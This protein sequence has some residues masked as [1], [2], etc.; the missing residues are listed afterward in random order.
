MRTAT[1]TADS[2]WLAKPSWWASLAAVLGAGLLVS[3]WI[4]AG[5]LVW[6]LAQRYRPF[7]FVLAFLVLVAGS[8]FVA[9]EAGGLTYQLS[10]VTAGV[11]VMLVCYASTVPGHLLGVRH[12]GMTTPLLLFSGLSFINIA[13]GLVVGHSPKYVLLEAFPLLALATTVLVS[14]AFRSARDLRLATIGLVLIAYAIGG[15]GYLTFLQGERHAVGEYTVAMPGIMGIFLVNLALRSRT[16]RASLGFV[17]VSLPLFVHQF[18]TFGR[19]LWTACAAGLAVS[20]LTHSRPG[21]GFGVRAR[22]AAAVLGLIVGMGTFGVVAAATFLDDTSI[23][24]AA[25]TRLLSITSTK[26]DYET[27]SNIIRLWEYATAYKLVLAS[28]W[29]GHGI[30]FQ[31]AVEDPLSRKSVDQLIV[32]QNYL[33]T[34]L[35]QGVVGLVLFVWLLGAAISLGIRA[36]WSATDPREAAWLA[37]SA[38]ATGFLAVLSLT[39]FPFARINEMFLLALLWGASM[40][41][42]GKTIYLEVRGPAGAGRATPKRADGAVVTGGA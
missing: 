6:L 3:W 19:G 25:G 31:F 14:N 18:L 40:A 17:L 4:G 37:T 29:V 28:P 42:V 7:D 41:M 20:L 26:L 27:R 2:I 16:W 21:P 5:L 1:R 12:T 10:Y 13:R 11:L 24:T 33:L 36:S 8:T 32:H 34:L 15:R 22:R 35:K 9:N 39:N 23:L 30:G 38:A